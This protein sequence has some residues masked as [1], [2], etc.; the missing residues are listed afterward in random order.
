MGC[1]PQLRLILLQQLALSFFFFFFFFFFRAE[2]NLSA[3]R[4]K[5][6]CW[7]FQ[8]EILCI[9]KNN[10]S[11][12]LNSN[13]CFYK[14]FECTKQFCLLQLHIHCTLPCKLNHVCIEIFQLEHVSVVKLCVGY[15]K[16]M[17]FLNIKLSKILK[18][19]KKSKS[20]HFN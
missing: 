11:R 18:K 16:N 7:I 13:F 6:H 9:L 19:E 12:K 20:G 4:L 17:S 15:E 14:L 3:P 8:N 2:P 10:Q 1:I 5:V